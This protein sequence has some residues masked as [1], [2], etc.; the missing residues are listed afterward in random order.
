MT[1]YFINPAPGVV[2]L[3]LDGCLVMKCW[4]DLVAE[5]GEE[6]ISI[7]YVLGMC[8]SFSQVGH[9]SVEPVDPNVQ[10]VPV[11]IHL[12]YFLFYYILFYYILVSPTIQEQWGFPQ[13]RYFSSNIYRL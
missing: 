5:F 9:T 11:N 6:K 12:V 10:K 7:G 2:C 13:Q 8:W 1:Y 4:L 3:Y